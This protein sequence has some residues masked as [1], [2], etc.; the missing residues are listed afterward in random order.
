MPRSVAIIVGSFLF[1]IPS[2]TY[3]QDT[4]AAPQPPV[5]REIQIRGAKEISEEQVRD[6]VRVRAGE[7]LTET[8]D[9]I[10]EL[11]ERD[12]RREGYAFAR[13][14]TTFDEATGVLALSID[15]GVIDEVEFE[16]VAPRLARM[17]AD[18]FA[19]RA[20]DVFNRP[21]A[22]QALDALLRPTRGAVSRD[23]RDRRTAF[24][25]VDRNGKRVL[26]INLR[27]PVGRFK[28]TT[29]MGEREDWFTAVDGL[30]PSLGFG[31]AVFD[32]EH[33]NHAY[34]AGHLS[35]KLASGNVGYALGFERPL[36][37]VPKL[38]VG[39][40]LHDLTATDD[41]WQISNSEASLAA[42]GPRRSFRDYY[43][44]RGV[45]L[46]GAL[47]VHSHAELLFAWRNERQEPL[48]VRSDFSIWNGD[49]S[50]RPNVA[51]RDGRLSAIVIGG[52]IDGENLDRESLD[53]S[54]RRH[55]LEAPFGAR[56]GN[57]EKGHDEWPIWRIDWTSEI[58]DAGALHSDFD[59]RRHIVSGR[60]LIPMSP[61]QDFQ[62]RAIGGWSQGELPPQ[63]LFA[64][65]GIGSVHGYEFKEAM[66]D[67]MQLF[68]LEYALGWRH[69]VQ[70]LGFF[71]AG[72]VDFRHTTA[73]PSAS[74]PWLKGV[75]WGIG[76]DDM[77]LEFGYRLD[78]VPSSLQVLLRFT[79]TF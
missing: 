53:A 62:V 55:Q 20:G 76:V 27:E 73:L 2:T 17:F 58:S 7:P 74:T 68:N 42:I 72:H 37:D 54:Y 63:R 57:W 70:L 19:L 40:E 50:F 10:S 60:A 71:D 36:F 22:R 39:G 23:L 51:A 61:H 24:D 13:A 78:A 33:F 46:S 38:F 59:F 29:E 30:V 8:T 31:A 47:R 52:T 12:Y 66:G 18:E 69:G 44:R 11:V 45:Q 14:K 67:R 21:R 64:I 26:V 16:G 49:D 75:G 48:A 79:R 15:E 41:H 3:A 56:L 28:L 1:V 25:L 43:R 77:R 65:G 35:V 9:R 4:P 32:H 5:V 6:V 34:V